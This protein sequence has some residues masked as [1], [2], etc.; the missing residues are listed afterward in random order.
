MRTVN[1]IELGLVEPNSEHTVVLCLAQD[2]SAQQKREELLVQARNQAEKLSKLKDAF[3]ANVSHE[4]RTPLNCII[5][6][7][8][9]L[10]H[11]PL[12]LQQVIIFV[13]FLMNRLKWSTC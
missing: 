6:M 7:S 2:V 11:S 1:S 12:S 10:L 13:I 8:S 3:V 9:L 5:G 4:L